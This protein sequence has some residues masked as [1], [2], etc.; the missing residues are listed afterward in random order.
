MALNDYIIKSGKLI[1]LK[2]YI[3]N[4]YPD[5]EKT[6][7]DRVF[8]DAIA[9]FV[10]RH[11][12][13]IR[14]DIDE[15]V[16]ACIIEELTSS[17][18]AQLR[19]EELVRTTVREI[20]KKDGFIDERYSSKITDWLEKRTQNQPDS[21]GQRVQVE[22]IIESE[23]KSIQ[24][25]REIQKLA[26][27]EQIDRLKK[28]CRKSALNKDLETIKDF[29]YRCDELYDIP[30]ENVQVTIDEVNVV[31]SPVDRITLYLMYLSMAARSKCRFTS[32]STHIKW[33]D[34]AVHIVTVIPAIVIILLSLPNQEEASLTPQVQI[35][36]GKIEYQQIERSVNTLPDLV[37]EHFAVQKAYFEELAYIGNQKYNPFPYSEQNWSKVRAYLASYNSILSE[38]PYFEVIIDVGME[39]NIDPRILFAI[40]GQE[41]SFVRK[42]SQSAE[43]I[44][45]NPFNVYVSWKE[46]NTEIRD[47]AEIAANTIL[48]TMEKTPYN[49][50]PIKALNKTY[51][52]DPRWWIGVDYFYTEMLALES[53]VLR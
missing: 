4:K 40:T 11:I 21:I 37:D 29:G 44:A 25:S 36:I 49:A 22:D 16:K 28:N 8:S 13:V 51:A 9:N 27:F 3:E 1:D 18:M 34:I 39:K 14:N 38:S 32:R 31:L 46:Y 2:A 52:E 20:I 6:E 33:N 17:F 53:R 41:Q 26:M 45:N 35:P 15:K 48:N 50:H 10:D 42:G 19:S 12:I 47:S 23:R 30:V 5:H 24:S 43:R 7:L